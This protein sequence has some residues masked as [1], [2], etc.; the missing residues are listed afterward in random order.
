MSRK[1]LTRADLDRVEQSVARVRADLASKR[2][3]VTSLRIREAS[4]AEVGRQNQYLY[5]SL[6][7]LFFRVG[8]SCP[9]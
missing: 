1:N 8:K 9:G 3:E 7:F 5:L 4:Q 6:S 2:E